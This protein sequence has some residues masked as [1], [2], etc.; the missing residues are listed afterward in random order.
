MPSTGIKSVAL[1]FMAIRSRTIFARLRNWRNIP[2]TLKI[3]LGRGS[4]RERLISSVNSHRLQWRPVH[5]LVVVHSIEISTG[6]F[7]PMTTSAQAV[8]I[9]WITSALVMGYPAKSRGYKTWPA[10]TGATFLFSFPL[11][12]IVFLI[13]DARNRRRKKQLERQ[14][15]GN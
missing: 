8:L 13:V 7:A 15:I 5:V 3:P 11:T 14:P 9:F 2:S 10:W 1:R 6:V 12:I 4:E